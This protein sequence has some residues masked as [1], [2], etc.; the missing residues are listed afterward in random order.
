MQP[1]SKFIKTVLPR[2]CLKDFVKNYYRLKECI[3]ENEG[4][5]QLGNKKD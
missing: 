2:K 1:L 5:N 3:A 4:I